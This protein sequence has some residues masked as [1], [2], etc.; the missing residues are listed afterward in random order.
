MK[1][2]TTLTTTC[3]VYNLFGVMDRVKHFLGHVVD[4]ANDMTVALAVDISF[5][6]TP[7]T[8]KCF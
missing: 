6:E 2:E 1:V 7:I 4:V 3:H 8:D 5:K